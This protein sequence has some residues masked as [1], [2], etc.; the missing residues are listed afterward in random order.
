MYILAVCRHSFAHVVPVLAASEGPSPRSRGT[1]P[2][3]AVV[4]VPRP[5]KVR[6]SCAGNR[7]PDQRVN[8]A[9]ANAYV[10]EHAVI[11]A[12]EFRSSAAGAQLRLDRRSGFRQRFE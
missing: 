1:G 7:P 6:T 2:L 11:H 9:A 12:R 3:T 8:F 10:A 5:A 4:A